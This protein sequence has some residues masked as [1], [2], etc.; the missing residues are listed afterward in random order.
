MTTKSA[1]KPKA[2]RKK[3]VRTKKPAP[4][5]TTARLVWRDVTCRVRCTPNYISKG[6]THIELIVVS[7]KGAPLPIT[8]TGYLSHF[9]DEDV[10]KR[11]GGPVPLFLAWI[12]RE[13]TSKAWA[14]TEF[15]W[16]QMDLFTK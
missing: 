11:A 8:S 4:K 10:L 1:S 5:M 9:L 14:K 16:R 2:A 12:E 15:K 13:A 3:A 6:W 7:P